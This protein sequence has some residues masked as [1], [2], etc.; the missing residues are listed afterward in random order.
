LHGK[1]VLDIGRASGYFS[2]ELERRGAEVTA[3]DLRSLLDKD[4]VGGDLVRDAIR[5]R[6]WAE[7]VPAVDD[8]FGDRLD[9]AVA[10]KLLESRVKPVSVRLA[11]ISP[12]TVPGTPFDLVFV[13][14]VLNH[15]QDP[16]GALQ[17]IASVADDLCIIANPIDPGET[18]SVPRARFVGRAGTGLSTWFLPNLACL[19]EMVY[20]AGFDEVVVTHAALD[21]PR[22]G[23][24][25]IRHTVLQARRLRD[26]SAAA[27]TW[28]NWLDHGS[29]ELA[30]A[31]AKT[32]SLERTKARRPRLL[33]RIASAL[34]LT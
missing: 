4:Y 31:Q 24:G 2:F 9:F 22:P 33:R 10:H 28:G 15:V 20:A 13:G 18:S 21:L 14:S 26:R 8:T 17:R 6:A 29:K 7:G 5:R 30:A 11:D 1:R 27:Q 34:R 25:P 32:I 16:I 23:T 12:E 3:T 19:E